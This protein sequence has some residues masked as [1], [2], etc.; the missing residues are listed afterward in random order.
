MPELCE[1]VYP[2]LEELETLKRCQAEGPLDQGEV[3]PVGR[4]LRPGGV[5]R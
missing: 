4:F 2:V 5:R 1:P 3:N